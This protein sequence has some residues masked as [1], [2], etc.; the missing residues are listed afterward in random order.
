MWYSSA[1]KIQVKSDTG[2]SSLCSPMLEV[3]E[4]SHHNHNIV[5]AVTR[6]KQRIKILK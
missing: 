2:D 1:G 4:N 3:P 5:Q 6:G